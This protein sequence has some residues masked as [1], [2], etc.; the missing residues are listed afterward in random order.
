MVKKY[1]A[2]KPRRDLDRWLTYVGMTEAEFDRVSDTFRDPRVWR[3]ESDRWVKDNIWGQSSA[4]GPIHLRDDDLRVWN[5][6]RERLTSRA[7]S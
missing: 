1:D 3:I 7:G 5:E 6:K 4:Y 2:V